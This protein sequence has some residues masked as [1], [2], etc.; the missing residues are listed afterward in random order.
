MSRIPLDIK[1]A[2]EDENFS[3]WEFLEASNGIW[4]DMTVNKN[5]KGDGGIVGLKRKKPAL[6]RL[7]LT[8]HTLLQHSS[9][10]QGKKE[11]GLHLQTTMFISKKRQHQ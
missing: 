11:V 2:F 6:I 7:T 8:H 4:S 3:S 9:Q 5:A 1:A 10:P